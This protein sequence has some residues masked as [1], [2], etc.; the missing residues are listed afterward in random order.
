MTYYAVTN[1]PNE[2][3]HFGIKGMKWG[4]LRTPEQLGHHKASKSTKPRSP[5][6]LK[7][8]AKLERVMR[9]GIAKA[10]ANWA[11]YNSPAAKAARTRKRNEKAFEKHLELAR[12]GR[13]K[14]KNVKTDDEL[15]RLQERLAL[16]N[17]ARNL[18]G[19]QKQSVGRRILTSIGDGVVEGVGK[20][21]SN[22]IANYMGTR[23]T[24]KAQAKNDID[25]E[26]RKA[27]YHNSLRGRIDESRERRAATRKVKREAKRAFDKKY[28]EAELDNATYE[29]K[30]H[31]IARNVGIGAK[32][33]AYL[34]G[35]SANKVLAER[36]PDYTYEEKEYQSRDWSNVTRRGR[37]QRMIDRAKNNSNVGGKSEVVRIDQEPSSNVK[38]ETDTILPKKYTV[39]E[40]FSI[41]RPESN[42]G[43]T[44]VN[45][46][47]RGKTYQRQRPGRT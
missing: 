44:Y 12:Q 37:G 42:G 38:Q 29:S 33:L 45:P 22:Y 40:G 1:D 11:A 5:A 27:R 20:G 30:A 17:A 21:T 2:L 16:E 18:S 24:G 32:N 15:Y 4:V 25:K 28:I 47:A 9:S 31:S 41:P 19:K 35:N 43:S 10:Q 26:R 46:R 13:L 6:Y 36:Y 8:S 3:M 14:Y 39:A 7:A 23:G 34:V